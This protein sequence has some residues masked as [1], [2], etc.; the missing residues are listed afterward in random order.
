[1]INQFDLFNTIDAAC[2][3]YTNKHICMTHAFKI[4]IIQ[5]LE[6]YLTSNDIPLYDKCLEE[7]ITN[8]AM[9]SV[10]K[11]NIKKYAFNYYISRYHQHIISA[12]FL[13]ITYITIF[14][15]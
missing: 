11:L 5:A 2:I 12:L 10:T 15:M 13:Y 1:M 9:T 14:Y 4:D 3:T 6:N 8:E 7:I